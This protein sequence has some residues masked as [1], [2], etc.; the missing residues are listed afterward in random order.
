M[1]AAIT[2]EIKCLTPTEKLHLMEELWN[3]LAANDE[4]LPIPT[5]HQQI[6]SADHDR[7]QSNPGQTHLISEYINEIMITPGNIQT[8]ASDAAFFGF[9]IFEQG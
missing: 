1:T 8:F 2:D 4:D 9:V 6:L 3:D 7:Y 5:W